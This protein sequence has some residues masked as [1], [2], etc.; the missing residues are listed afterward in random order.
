MVSTTVTVASKSPLFEANLE[1]FQR[2]AAREFF[3]NVETTYPSGVTWTEDKL[4]L[5]AG[6]VLTSDLEFNKLAVSSFDDAEA[7]A[8][9]AVE[10][11]CESGVK[12]SK[13]KIRDDEEAC[14]ESCTQDSYRVNYKSFC[15]FVKKRG[16][17]ALMLMLADQSISFPRY[18]P[19]VEAVRGAITDPELAILK[20][21]FSLISVSGPTLARWIRKYETE[22]MSILVD[23]SQYLHFWKCA[24]ELE[25]NSV[26]CN[27]KKYRYFGP[28]LGWGQKGGRS[29]SR[30]AAKR[31][32]DVVTAEEHCAIWAYLF[33]SFKLEGA[34]YSRSLEVK[35]S[36][37]SDCDS[38]VGKVTLC[39]AKGNDLTHAQVTVSPSI[40][41]A[42]TDEYTRGQL[43][44]NHLFV[45]HAEQPIFFKYADLVFAPG[46]F[47][48]YVGIPSCGITDKVCDFLPY[49]AI[50]RLESLRILRSGTV[51]DKPPFKSGYHYIQFKNG[52]EEWD[53][54]LVTLLHVCVD[55]LDQI[56]VQDPKNPKGER[57]PNPEYVGSS[58]VFSAGFDGA[59][60]AETWERFLLKAKVLFPGRTIYF[61]PITSAPIVVSQT[62][63]DH[64]ISSIELSQ[65]KFKRMILVRFDNTGTDNNYTVSKNVRAIDPCPAAILENASLIYRR[66]S[67]GTPC[68]V[69]CKPKSLRMLVS[70][71]CAPTPKV[72]ANKF[73]QDVTW[74]Q[75]Y[76]NNVLDHTGYIPIGH[77]PHTN[78]RVFRYVYS[79]SETTKLKLQV[80]NLESMARW[81][82]FETLT[83]S[84][85]RF[86]PQFVYVSDKL[87]ALD[88]PVDSRKYF[89]DHQDVSV[90]ETTNY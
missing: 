42:S 72:F 82:V 7:Y 67:W 23:F 51:F 63:K 1:F 75:V 27:S 88:I 52:H 65:P 41:F 76:A 86:A 25:G 4:E 59:K 24:Y 89:S 31:G 2:V 68:S 16:L 57:V 3:D 70:D 14:E 90:V 35:I 84:F 40:L 6:I 81:S 5:C 54:L 15:D 11:L 79:S 18:K 87:C 19:Y 64:I 26:V 48:D 43:V 39:D 32:S 45:E 50:A 49:E 56:F 20:A 37:S 61:C 10:R 74:G 77:N 55:I 85:A 46:K 29:V 21:E 53:P 36:T 17:F 69:H 34:R 60:D 38:I 78:Q 28:F 80:G 9:R 62:I 58:V 13:P 47:L 33:K 66:F 22:A 44:A 73:V 8:I 12:T 83:C 30:A 71:V